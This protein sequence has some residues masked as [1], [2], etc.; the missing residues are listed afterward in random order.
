[1]KPSYVQK[2]GC[3]LKYNVE[4]KCPIRLD[5]H[6]T[7]FMNFN[8]S[9]IGS[10]TAFGLYTYVRITTYIVFYSSVETTNIKL[11]KWSTSFLQE[12]AQD[13]QVYT[14]R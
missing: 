7:I 11:L 2:Y 6:R 4:Q 9:T 13:S 1:M 8:I 14:G 10:Y 3:I 5:K 12:K